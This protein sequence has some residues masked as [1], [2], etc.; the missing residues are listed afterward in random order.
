MPTEVREE[1]LGRFV[2][3]AEPRR[4]VGLSRHRGDIA[5][6]AVVGLAMAEHL[7]ARSGFAIVPHIALL[8][9]VLLGTATAGW[10]RRTARR[11]R[12]FW[13]SCDA[14]ARGARRVPWRAAL[15]FVVVPSWLLFLSNGR[16][17]GAVD[18]R[19]VIPTA[20]SVWKDGDVELSEYLATGPGPSLRNRSGAIRGCFRSGRWGIYSSYPAGMVPFAV[21]ATG[22]ADLAGADLG[23][24]QVHPRLEKMTASCVAAV[25]VGLF[26]LV[27]LRL[28]PT[29]PALVASATLAAGSG[30]FSTVGMALWQHGGSSSG[31][32]WP[33]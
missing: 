31:H 2:V 9:V 18:T 10:R 5:M 4:A 12:E 14:F 6:I 23:N 7:R 26:F 28:A 16:P 27:S 30:I 19:P 22:L 13:G 20:V 17:I 15:V 25:A 33:S 11:L 24:P 1:T 3:V 29:G 8:A 21:V 32:C